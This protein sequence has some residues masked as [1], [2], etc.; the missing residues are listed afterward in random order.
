MHYFRYRKIVKFSK[1]CNKACIISGNIGLQLE[2]K[3]GKRVL[4]S[5]QWADEIN[6]ILIQLK[7]KN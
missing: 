2:L 3:N 1:F 7:F 4:L 6:D 5:T